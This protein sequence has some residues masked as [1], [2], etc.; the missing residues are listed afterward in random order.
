MFASS[1]WAT[2]GASAAEA[3]PGTAPLK[4]EVVAGAGGF[5]DFVPRELSDHLSASIGVPVLVENRPGAGGNIATAVVAKAQPDGHTLLVTSTNQTVNPVL[6]PNPGFDYERDLA[7]VSMVVAAKLVIV[8]SP[9][10]PGKDITDIV[11]I[12]KQKPKSVSIAIPAIGTPNHLAALMLAQFGDIDL[13]IVPY[14][15]SAQAIPDVMEGRVDLA[16]AAIST[17]LP[18]IRRGQLKAMAVLSPQR[19]PL[20][21]DIPTSAEA[22]MPQL[23]IDNW[24]CIMTTGGTPPPII[25]R[26]DQEIGKA[27]ALPDVRDAF[28]KQGVEIFYMNAERLGSFL[29]SEAARY[30]TLLKD[31]R[32][33]DGSQ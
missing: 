5:V 6:F 15:G 17:V 24:V 1:L 31:T 30:G 10:F 8:A 25:A 18:L 20:A 12:A 22:G 26:L 4:F 16:V 2:Q 7:P 11:K 29:Q 27:L 13:T 19:S 21:P 23:Q 14:G 9:F 28:A 32:A 33:K 3:W